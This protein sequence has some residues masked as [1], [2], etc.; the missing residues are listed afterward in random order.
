MGEKNTN[1]FL[2][3]D[4]ILLAVFLGLILLTFDLG[5]VVF[6]L[7]FFLILFLLFA[8]FISLL[9]VYNGVDWGWPSLSLI[10]AVIL[11]DL[12]LVY[13]V[14]RLVNAVYFFT[15]IAAAVGFIIAVIS[16]KDRRL[17]KLEEEMEPYEEAVTKYTPGKYITSRRSIYYHAPKC[18]WAKKIR[19]KNQLWLSEEDVKKKGLKK[20]N[21]LK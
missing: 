12:L 4:L 10:F 18:D 7:Q 6:G 8:S 19:K 13:S 9:V 16:V 14:N 11:I 5:G 17:E 21:C 20:H 3:V 15:T 1:L 2:A